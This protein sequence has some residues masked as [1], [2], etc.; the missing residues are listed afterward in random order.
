MIHELAKYHYDSLNWQQLSKLLAEISNCHPPGLLRPDDFLAK[1]PADK[2]REGLRN[3]DGGLQGG[4][5]AGID[6]DEEYEDRQTRKKR[7]QKHQRLMT[8]KSE[9][10][11]ER[12][13]FII[14]NIKF[15]NIKV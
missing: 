11:S 9:H 2:F 14:T 13:H 15:T 12:K 5:G 7:E 4:L 3:R 8:I 10:S 6:D 1:N